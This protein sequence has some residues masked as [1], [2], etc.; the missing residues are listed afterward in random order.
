MINKERVRQLL[1]NLLRSKRNRIL[2]SFSFLFFLSIAGVYFWKQWQ[3]FHIVFNLS[4]EGYNYQI[5]KCWKTKPPSYWI[6]RIKEGEIKSVKIGKCSFRGEAIRLTESKINFD[7]VLNRNIIAQGQLIKNWDKNY[8]QLSSVE[9]KVYT[10]PKPTPRPEEKLI[11]KKISPSGEEIIYKRGKNE[12][13]QIVQ[14]QDYLFFEPIHGYSSKEKLVRHDLNTGQTDV[15]Y[16]EEST[17]RYLSYIQLIDSTLYFSVAGYLAGADTFWLDS[18]TGSPQKL[19][20]D[21]E[22]GA[23][24]IEYEHGRYWLKGGEGDACWGIATHALFDPK[25]KIVTPIATSYIGCIEGEEYIAIDSQDRMI[26]AYHKNKAGSKYPDE[27]IYEYIVAIPLDSPSNKQFLIT[28]ENMPQFIRGI[29][30]SNSQNQLALVGDELYLFDLNS[31]NLKKI[32]D[33]P[34]NWLGVKIYN[35]QNN[36]LCLVREFFSSAEDK[37]TYLVDLDTG[38]IEENTDYCKEDLERRPESYEERKNKELEELISS[39]DLPDN[40]KVVIE[41]SQ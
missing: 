33:F 28:K 2:I 12:D 32:V 37:N 27:Q 23:S 1:R 41:V 5:T 29:K 15:V 19:P 34:N 9:L 7:K 26:M 21:F 10:P 31:L 18:P 17:R 40:Y 8:Y 11:I 39:L 16:R 36:Q 3:S 4:E 25:T 30:Y 38:K 14:W 20:E 13:H 24:R 22:F 35:W 6:Q